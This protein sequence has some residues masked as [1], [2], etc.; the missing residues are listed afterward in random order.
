MITTG[1]CRLFRRRGLSVAPFKAQNIALN[2]YV[3]LEGHEIGRSQ[4]VQAEA[5]G[6]EPTVDMN[7]VLLKPEGD[8]RCQVIVMG[9][10]ESGWDTSQFSDR[11]TYLST[12]VSSSL[13]RLRAQYDVVV[14]EG[15]GSPAEIN[16][17]E[18]DIVNMH[19]ALLAKAPILLVGD[20]DLGGVFA[21]FYGTLG[22]LDETD[23][24][25]FAGLLINK[26]RGDI[27][28]LEPGI[29]MIEERVGIPILGV[30]PYVQHLRIAEEDGVALDQRKNVRRA[31]KNEIEIAVVRFPRISNYDDFMALEHEPGVVVR[32]VES[33][34]E[35]VEA[36]LVILPGTKDTRAD[37]DW[38]RQAGMESVLT[39]RAAQGLPIL[40]VCGGYQM[41]GRTIDDP[42]GIE[43]QPGSTTGL[44]LL[45]V[46]TRFRQQKTTTRRS[47]HPATSSGSFMTTGLN[48]QAAISGYEIHMG[49]VLLGDEATALFVDSVDQSARGAVQGSVSGTLLHGLFENTEL[50]ASMLGSLRAGRKGLPVFTPS[51]DLPSTD[52][53]YDRLAEVLEGCLDMQRIDELLAR[54]DFPWTE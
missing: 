37:L 23:R 2:S 20:I 8:S 28:L 11:K 39:E 7:P 35:L 21:H 13:E 6:I 50:R 17:R 24:A 34:A 49:D 47:F 22:L 42:G 36:D 5:A 52:Q 14:I 45:P 9:R 53:E 51:S 12:V 40:G 48:S 3:T 41:L 27:G 15:A 30:V 25:Q 46:S 54:G 29:K 1:L 31:T 43:G 33:A 4:A 19:V 18:N 26:F 32:Y 16:L 44:G 38:L 10:P